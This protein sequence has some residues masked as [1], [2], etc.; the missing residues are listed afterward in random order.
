ML[1]SILCV[2]LDDPGCT[3]QNVVISDTI[4]LCCNEKA[5]AEKRE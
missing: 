2:M 3:R 1:R 5:K 4:T